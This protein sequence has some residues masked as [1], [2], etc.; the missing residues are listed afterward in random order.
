VKRA[1][2][3][4]FFAVVFVAL[5]VAANAPIAPPSEKQY[6]DFVM[7]DQRIVDR[8]TRLSW[9]RA[10][11]ASAMFTTAE[12]TICTGGNPPLRV[13][14]LKELLTLVDEEPNRFYDVGTGTE[15]DK[16]IDLPAFRDSPV[17]VPYW[18]SSIDPSGARYTVDFRT[19]LTGTA[20]VTDLRRVRCV[21]TLP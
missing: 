12:T 9:E 20:L 21:R 3:A 8:F 4:M 1:R 17:D 10:V 13:P 7:A 15:I 11:P 5:P 14:T 19:G 16:M 6:E 18:T 2:A